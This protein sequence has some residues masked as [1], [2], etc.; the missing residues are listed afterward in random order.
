MCNA[1]SYIHYIGLNDNFITYYFSLERCSQCVMQGSRSSV[2]HWELTLSGQ[3]SA[4]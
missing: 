2:S 4:D 1:E 3:L